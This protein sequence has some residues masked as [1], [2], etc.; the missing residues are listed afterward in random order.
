MRATLSHRLCRLLARWGFPVSRRRN[1]L[2]R[3]SDVAEAWT[4]VAAVVLMLLLAP[5]L[6]W[7]TGSLAHDALRETVRAQQ[8]HRHLVTATALPVP[9]GAPEAGPGQESST[10]R[11]G[12]HH[13]LASW[14]CPGGRECT[15]AVAVRRFAGPGEHF[16]LWTDDAGRVAT[17]P[18]DDAAAALH[19]VLA[20]VATA[21]ACAGLLEGGRRL[22]VWRIVRRRYAQWDEEWERAAGTWGRADT[23]S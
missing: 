1:P 19:A 14:P 12:F 23:G 16:P 8:R 4:G 15:G 18:M 22:V 11:D 9:A 3:R 6:G 5:P 21:G 17:R 7:L 2:L 10:G 13:V 20:G